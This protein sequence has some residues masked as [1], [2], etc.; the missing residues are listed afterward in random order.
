MN[1][2]LAKRSG[3]AFNSE[4]ATQIFQFFLVV[5]SQTRRPCLVLTFNSV[6][7]RADHVII[8]SFQPFCVSMVENVILFS[9]GLHTVQIWTV[10]LTGPKECPSWN[11]RSQPP[12]GGFRYCGCQVTDCR[13]NQVPYALKSEIVNTARFL[14]LFLLTQRIFFLF[15]S[16]FFYF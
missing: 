15:S 8:C 4:L 2:E 10:P 5:N 12:N 16:F 6:G 3:V 9:L 14:F 13:L 11:I 7:G 1:S